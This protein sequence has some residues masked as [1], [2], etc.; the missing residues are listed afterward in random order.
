[1]RA[2]RDRR[3][4]KAAA[5]CPNDEARQPRSRRPLAMAAPE[6]ADL[7]LRDRQ[8]APYPVDLARRWITDGHV[9]LRMWN[10]RL[11]KT[12]VREQSS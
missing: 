5:A 10:C 4:S 1:M 9:Q 6:L 8:P 2:A 11:P 12:R 7:G 3:T